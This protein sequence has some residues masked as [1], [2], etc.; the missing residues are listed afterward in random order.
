MLSIAR[1][2]LLALVA[3]LVALSGTAGAA[4]AARLTHAQADAEVAAAQR[5][6]GQQGQQGRIFNGTPL[7]I[8]Q[9]PWQVL[10]Y[11][12]DGEGLLTCGGSIIGPSTVVTA[13]H[14]VSDTQDA[15]LIGQSPNG[16]GGLGIIAG[17]SNYHSSATLASWFHQ[18]PAIAPTD[19]E[20]ART[21]TAAR[22]H[23]GWPADE[24]GIDRFP[25][26]DVAVLT[27][28]SPLTYSASTPA[29]R[30]IALAP[31]VAPVNGDPIPF[32]SSVFVAGFGQQVQYKNGVEQNPDGGLYGESLSVVDRDVCGSVVDAAVN[33]CAQTPSGTT[34][35]GDS[36]SGLVTTD[37]PPLLVGLVSAG[38]DPCVSGN[39]T[40]FTSLVAPENRQF[41]D[42]NNA[43]PR[44]PR[45]FSDINAGSVFP[46]SVGGLLT[47]YGG[48]FQPA[49][50]TK[51]S[52]TNDAG[53]QVGQGTGPS[54]GYQPTAADIGSHLWCRATV[55][56]PG[57][58]AQSERASSAAIVTQT[59][60][61]GLPKTSTIAP[62]LGTTPATVI[63]QTKASFAIVATKQARRGNVVTVRAVVSNL[64]AG[65]D[66]AIATVPR[67]PTSRH[68]K[69]SLASITN[70]PKAG[71]A[72]TSFTLR[73]R[74]PKH[75]QTG[76]RSL[77][78]QVYVYKL[79][80]LVSSTTQTVRVK[81]T[82]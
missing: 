37:S 47:C 6:Q 61:G 31:S 63:P 70:Y 68:A 40:Y 59:S 67:I 38:Q 76:I 51:W 77:K 41:L 57:G 13:A 50:L 4:P 21:V 36:G 5:Q 2:S 71:D 32:T 62:I 8:T 7:S 79:A 46:L 15:G 80:A 27:L 75:A 82:R 10:V 73:V 11:S 52:V 25:S 23:P 42:G 78:V 64:P 22:V 28:G 26:G 55:S 14:C 29:I 48:A 3:S 81:I 17:I 58:V 20:E 54:F 44:A 45:Q 33:I 30:P 66:T 72:T 43:P 60:A 69:G 34:C 39:P 65:A 9:S 53:A 35:H 49:T 74:V 16:A 56:S 1:S 19:M 24:N 18:T 12:D